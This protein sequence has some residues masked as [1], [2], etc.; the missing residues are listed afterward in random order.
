MKN[1]GLSLSIAIFMAS[2][3]NGENAQTNAGASTEAQA[4]A[5]ISP[6]DRKPFETTAIASF[7]EPWAMTFLPDGRML[8]SEKAGTL[9]LVDAK[10]QKNEISGVPEVAY[11]GQGGFGDIVLAPDFA[12]SN[13]VYLSWVE[14]GE[15]DSRGAV[16]GRARLDL[17]GA[18]PALKNL[19]TVWTQKPKVTG[20]GHYSHRIAFSP[21]GEY[22][23]I[24]S[25]DRQKFDPAQDMAANLGK[26]VRLYP[27]GSIPKD[28]PFV[29]QDGALPE[30]WSLGHRN[31]LGLAFDGK[32]RLWNQEMGP[33]DG[34]ELNLVQR[35]A[36]YGYPV[37][38]EG[39]HY[40]GREIPNH[41]SHPEF[42]AP[43]V[44][45]VPTIAP[46]GLIFYSGD[47]FPAWR[48]SAFIGGL[49]SQALIRVSFE[50]DSAKEAERFLMDARIRE[51]EQGPD[52]AIYVLED[53]KG[54]R[55]LKLTPA[56]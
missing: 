10:G 37:V 23:F 7:D 24:G 1:L 43:K 42:E 31:I 34:D 32:G 15:D 53:G 49:A 38:S 27:D 40:D 19:R 47:L 8:V 33:K 30:I 4:L 25:G 17:S 56:K 20:K 5:D 41:D 9:Q 16:V 50:E 52:G 36:N 3:T 11:G 28:N 29:D 22:L 51:V 39:D 13:M 48:G 46:S 54:G 6:V 44:A 12:T 14:A 55:L 21:D 2:C 26:I 18:K 35:A 45:W